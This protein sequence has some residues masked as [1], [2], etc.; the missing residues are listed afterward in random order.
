MS[1]VEGKI[2]IF[3]ITSGPSLT[4]DITIYLPLTTQNI[5]TLCDKFAMNMDYI[6]SVWGQEG[7]FSC[8]VAS[9]NSVSPCFPLP[10]RICAVGGQNVIMAIQ[11]SL[12]SIW[13]LMRLWPV[14]P[15]GRGACI[16]INCSCSSYLGD[17]EDSG[18]ESSHPIISSLSLTLLII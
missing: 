17:G 9:W 11:W 1:I 6:V 16:I 4:P 14:M 5:D 7:H 10:V 13:R 15:G 2:V 18:R 8:H 12:L 3:R